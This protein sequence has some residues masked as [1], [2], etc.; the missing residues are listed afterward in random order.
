MNVFSEKIYTIGNRQN[1]NRFLFHLLKKGSLFFALGLASNSALALSSLPIHENTLNKIDISSHLSPKEINKNQTQDEFKREQE[2]YQKTIKNITNIEMPTQMKKIIDSEDPSEKISDIPNI[3]NIL[4]VWKKNGVSL[5]QAN[6]LMSILYWTQSPMI[7]TDQNFQQQVKKNR[8]SAQIIWDIKTG[9]QASNFLYHHNLDE[10]VEMGSISQFEANTVSSASSWSELKKNWEKINPYFDATQQNLTKNDARED[11]FK[12]DDLK[13]VYQNLN[14]MVSQVGLKGLRVPLSIWDSPQQIRKLTT[15]LSQM[16]QLLQSTTHLKNGVMG[17][18][19]FVYTPLSVENCVTYQNKQGDIN[20]ISSWSNYAHEWFH[21]LQANLLSEKKN[22][23]QNFKEKSMTPVFQEALDK[24]IS[25]SKSQGTW[26]NNLESFL[27]K[28]PTKVPNWSA[29]FSTSDELKNY[30]TNPIEMLAYSWGAYI[31]TKSE[32]I[33]P[34]KQNFHQSQN[35]KTSVFVPSKNE[36]K[37][38]EFIW[39][40]LMKNIS[41][42]MTKENETNLFITNNLTSKNIADKITAQRKTQTDITH[43]IKIN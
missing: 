35:L 36:A 38:M 32:E 15:D 26:I 16:N 12:K 34:T 37:N 13:M 10:Y 21:G 11:H 20:I 2:G 31:E 3:S 19:A 5:T 9:Q 24:M 4:Q 23:S 42:N 29:E 40:D 22:L 8:Q 28:N 41:Q 30:Y 39:L 27:N 43:A 18:N 6:E 25:Y 17:L 33:F 1:T 14:E 7:T